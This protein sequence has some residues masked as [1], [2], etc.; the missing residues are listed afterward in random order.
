[1]PSKKINKDFVLS[2]S[3]VNVY[4]FRLL[5]EG[6]MLDEVMKNP[7]GYYGHDKEDGVLLKWEDI[8]LD[9]DRILG[10]P[11]INMEHP[12]AERTVQEIEEGFLNA[13]SVGN[14]H[15]EEYHLEDNPNDSENPI[16]VGTKWYYK[17]CSLVDSPGNRNAFKLYD[18]NE[19]PINLSDLTT[20]FINKSKSPDMRELQLKIT[21]ALVS[22]LGLSD[23]ADGTELAQKI[24]DLN[25]RAKAGDKAVNENKKLTTELKDLK[26]AQTAKAVSDLL[27]KGM[28]DKKLTVAM[29]NK[30]ATDYAT[31]PEGLKDLMD[32]LPVHKSIMDDMNSG[33][34]TELGD[35][36]NKSWDEL[37]KEDRLQ[38][39][40]DADMDAFKKKFKEKF[41]K[42][43]RA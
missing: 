36:A 14:I 41:G 9:G 26:E 32:T 8:R 28:T 5:T 24:S 30:L 13:A 33:S 29:K 21:P 18:A 11:V 27:D 34:K 7:I 1:M 35:M 4:G 17:E 6:C 16:L 23:N 25:D 39:L 40:K 10:K 22:M 31:N 19:Q 38:D 37:D 12:R 20:N 2:D 42:E 3:S 15:L 43:Y